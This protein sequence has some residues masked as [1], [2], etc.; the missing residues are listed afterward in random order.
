MNAG[1]SSREP[2]SNGWHQFS[3]LLLFV[4]L[5]GFPLVARVIL[6]LT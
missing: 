5:S 4:V 6:H 3:A 2:G 1:K